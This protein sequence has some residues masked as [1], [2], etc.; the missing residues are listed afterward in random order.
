VLKDKPQGG[1]EDDDAIQFGHSLCAT[2]ARYDAA[3]ITF[4]SY[5]H[6]A[7]AGASGRQ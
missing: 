2:G 1:E 3:I 5:R 6:C 7:G 4:I